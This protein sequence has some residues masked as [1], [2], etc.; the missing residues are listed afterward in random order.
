MYINKIRIISDTE[1]QNQ[2]F[3]IHYTIDIYKTNEQFMK[4]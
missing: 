1:Q 4:N 2:A 3:D